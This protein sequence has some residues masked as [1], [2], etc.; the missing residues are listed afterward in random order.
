MIFSKMEHRAPAA[1]VAEGP[2]SLSSGSGGVSTVSTFEPKPL[3][4]PNLLERAWLKFAPESGLR[5]MVARQTVREFGYDAAYPGTLRGPSGGHAK[6][7][8]SR[9][10][11]GDERCGE[12][13]V[14]CADQVRNNPIHGGLVDKHCMYV[15]GRL[16]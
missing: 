2:R 16:S 4:K 13:H 9:E 12:A 3:V 6:N 11:A 1:P 14:G 10:L 7:A 5:H 15:T 8:A